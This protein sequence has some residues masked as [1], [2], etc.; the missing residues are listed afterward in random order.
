MLRCLIS[1]VWNKL[2]CKDTSEKTARSTS[3]TQR[4]SSTMRM[5]TRYGVK[6]QLGRLGTTISFVEPATLEQV[7][8]EERAREDEEAVKE[9]EVMEVKVEESVTEE[10]EGDDEELLDVDLDMFRDDS[11]ISADE[12]E[13]A[14]KGERSKFKYTMTLNWMGEK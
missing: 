8:E 3:G 4:E 9:K 5:M 13:D 11:D 7:V 10:K 14:G 2:C 12:D 1:Q 6:P